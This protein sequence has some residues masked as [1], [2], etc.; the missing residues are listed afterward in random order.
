M[1]TIEQSAGADVYAARVV[2]ALNDG[3]TT[4]MTSIGH[5]TGLFD[6]MAS[7][8]AATSA[9]IA[10]AAGLAERY[11]RAWLESMVAAR[12]VEHEPQTGTYV[13]PIE[14]AAVL[15]RAAG[16]NNLARLAQLLPML[17]SMEELVVAG[18]RSGGGVQPEA[19]RRF[20]ALQCERIDEEFVNEVLSR[21]PGLREKL[22]RGASVLDAGCG[23]GQVL[24]VLARMFPRTL[25]RGY[26]SS[27]G[28]IA[29]TTGRRN[30]V[31]DVVNLATLDDEPEE[32]DL[33]TCFDFSDDPAAL[34]NVARSLK[35]DGLFVIRHRA[36]EEGHPFAPLLLAVNAMQRVPVAIARGEM[37][38]ATIAESLVRAGFTSLRFERFPSD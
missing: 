21:I 16:S 1:S 18:F 13:L 17:A 20:D 26:D 8:P 29:G 19:F 25:F 37:E 14:Y 38:Q 30:L 7:L 34:A 36:A 2:R 4:L 15:T 35:K 28:A 27:A 24:H 12:I 32:Y 6:A 33:I 23:R 11:V 22:V 5:R 9:R 10:E 3:F 31:F